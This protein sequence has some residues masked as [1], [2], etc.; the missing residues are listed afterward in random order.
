MPEKIVM[1]KKLKEGIDYY[2]N[3]NGL[4]VFTAK[5][6]AER[7]YCCGNGCLH[8]PYKNSEIK[9]NTTAA[10]NKNYCHSLNL[11]SK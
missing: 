10:S 3:E 7:N 1:K 2:V 6:L 5:Y 11:L 8:C 4:F 9:K